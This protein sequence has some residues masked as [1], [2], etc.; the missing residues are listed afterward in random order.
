ML[1]DRENALEMLNFGS[2]ERITSGPP[3]YGI[4]YY[5]QNPTDTPEGVIENPQVGSR[6]VDMWG[7]GNHKEHEGV[8]AFP[9][10]PPIP[11]PAAL[12]DYT[13]MDPDD[14][15]ICGKIYTDYE[16]APEGTDW[17]SG[18]HRCLLWERAYK[19][20]GMENL[21]MY[22]YTEPGFIK[23]VFHHIMDFNL[24]IAKHY[25]KLG[26][27]S[28]GY[29]DDLGS[30]AGPLFG[31]NIFDE[32]FKPEYKRFYDMYRENGVYVGTHSCGRIDMFIE[33]WIELGLSSLN[34]IQVS[35]NDLDLV[36]DKT[37]GRLVLHGAISNIVLSEGTADD[38]RREVRNRM[39]QLGRDGGYFACP[40][41]YM[42][43]PEENY[44]TMHEA[45]EEF[46]EYPL[47]PPDEG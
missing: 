5:G 18:G 10:V 38:V 43:W 46:G 34:P 7:I 2:P 25:L 22:F 23:D 16:N 27:T 9:E 13:W 37:K 41:Q 11:E 20:T 36:R 15:K 40:D 35:A 45:I 30:Q 29:S 19:L 17:F 8:M 12:K 42:P 47:S 26:V 31:M 6:W 28:V 33:S 39:W 1:T 3:G 44:Q 32:F 14:E 24:G 4:G 21:M